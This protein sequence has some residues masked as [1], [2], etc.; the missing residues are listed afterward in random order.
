[1]TEFLFPSGW[2]S[3]LDKTSGVKV[4]KVISVKEQ[5]GAAPSRKSGPSLFMSHQ[6]RPVIIAAPLVVAR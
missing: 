4:V 2:S 5:D 6:T 3:T 1:M